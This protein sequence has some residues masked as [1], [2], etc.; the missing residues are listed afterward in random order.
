MAL[1]D[2]DDVV[3]ERAQE[4]VMAH[5]QRPLE[6]AGPERN[7][8]PHWAQFLMYHPYLL[9]SRTQVYV[10]HGR[11]HYVLH[12]PAALL[13]LLVALLVS[14]EVTRSARALIPLQLL[15][16]HSVFL[17]FVHRELIAQMMRKRGRGDALVKRAGG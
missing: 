11:L 7:F 6:S 8:S 12:H 9:V 5:G 10:R 16:T 15:A 2:A 4:V 1:H 17:F 3:L 13:F 14:V